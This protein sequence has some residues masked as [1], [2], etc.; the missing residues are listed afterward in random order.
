[1]RDESSLHHEHEREQGQR[2]RE[3]TRDAL[4]RISDELRRLRAEFDAINQPRPPPG[5]R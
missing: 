3:E 1:M 4:A 2:E 5:E